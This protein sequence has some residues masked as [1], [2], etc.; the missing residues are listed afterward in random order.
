MAWDMGFAVFRD[1][2]SAVGLA[3]LKE[4]FGPIMWN[5]G[6]RL[7]G[8]EEPTC[9]STPILDHIGGSISVGA[10]A[11]AGE[12]DRKL[13]AARRAEFRTA[14][15]AGT[16]EAARKDCTV[17]FGLPSADHE[18]LALVARLVNMVTGG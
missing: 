10:G 9:V 14:A 1:K 6:G 8:A 12:L 18:T 11:V 5:L 7:V 3:A 17:I 15:E 16:D 13:A 4:P 2:A